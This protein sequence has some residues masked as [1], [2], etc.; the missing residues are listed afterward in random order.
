[1]KKFEIGDRVSFINEKQDGFIAKLLPNGNCMV[2]IEDGFEIEATVSELIKISV[3]QKNRNSAIEVVKQEEKAQPEEK[4][5]LSKLLSGF[6]DAVTFVLMPSNAQQVLTGSVKY[7]LV[8]ESKYDVL[9]TFSNKK[10]KKTVGISSGKIEAANEI[11]IGEITRDELMDAESLQVQLLFHQINLFHQIGVVTKDL[12]IE[13]PDLNHTNKNIVGAAAFCKTVKLISFAETAE[14]DL[15]ELVRKFQA[16][17][18]TSLPKQEASQNIL[19]KSKDQFQQ[20]NVAPG[21]IEVDLHIEELVD[22]A[23]GLTNTQMIEIQL[24]HFRKA[25]DS[26]LL[27]KA[28]KITFIH[29][30]GNGRLKNA[31]R[32]EIENISYLRFGDAP[33]E[34]YGAGATEV[35]LK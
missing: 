33:F 32:T 5:I 31:I 23:S 4:I 27:R 35:I 9:F 24:Q 25:I 26:A 7:F 20:Y 13:Y 6:S 14:E 10:N 21:L 12:T 8:N 15:S 22:D 3:T 17:Q 1:M 19:N 28:H 34:K 30:V 2:E 29:G 16:D 18:P 11:C